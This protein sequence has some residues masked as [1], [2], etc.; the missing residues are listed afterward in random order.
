[1]VEGR[2]GESKVDEVAD[3]VVRGRGVTGRGGG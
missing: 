1:M 3:P 2:G